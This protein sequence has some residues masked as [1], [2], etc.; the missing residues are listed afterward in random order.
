MEQDKAVTILEN[1]IPS[2]CIPCQ[3]NLN[4]SAILM[5]FIAGAIG[6]IALYK[7]LENLFKKN[8]NKYELKSSKYAFCMATFYDKTAKE[9]ETRVKTD[10]THF[11]RPESCERKLDSVIDHFSALAA[12]WRRTAKDRKEQEIEDMRYA[13]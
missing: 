4:E 2:G 3:K 11:D 1:M 9:Y 8:C 7:Y 6:A 10:C 13:K 5:S 12:Q